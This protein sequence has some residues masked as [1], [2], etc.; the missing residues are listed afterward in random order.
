MNIVTLF[1]NE[2]RDIVFY[3]RHGEALRPPKVLR[4]GSGVTLRR[5]QS[6]R[7]I[8]RSGRSGQNRLLFYLL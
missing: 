6:R 8:S 2:V 5:D 1:A 3:T 7:E 4:K